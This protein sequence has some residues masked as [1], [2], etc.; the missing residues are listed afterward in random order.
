MQKAIAKQLQGFFP[1]GD[2]KQLLLF[3]FQIIYERFLHFLK[4]KNFLDVCLAKP[5]YHFPIFLQ[6]Y[7]Y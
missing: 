4:T 6:I 5:S 1:Y 7:L 2:K 3:C